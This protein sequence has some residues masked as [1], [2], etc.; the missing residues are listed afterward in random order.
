MRRSTIILTALLVVFIEQVMV[1]QDISVTAKVDTNEVT[2]GDWINLSL[3]VER[4]EAVRV[5]WPAILDT[6]AHLEVLRRGEIQTNKV[7]DK[8]VETSRCV[9]STIDSGYHQIP[10]IQFAY[11]VGNDTAKRLAMTYPIDLFV[12]TVPVDTTQDIK[13]VKPPLGIPIALWEIL[14]YVGI[15]LFIAGGGF[16]IYY[17]FRRRKDRWLLS[18]LPQR[19]PQDLA[20][21]ELRKLEDEKLWQRGLVKPYYTRVTEIVR[22]YIEGRFEVMALE[23]TTVEVM[24]NVREIAMSSEVRETLSVFLNEADFVKFAKYQPTPQENEAE[25]KMA[26]DI[27]QGTNPVVEPSITEEQTKVTVEDV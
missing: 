13:D 4:T 20:L 3:Q 21:I 24:H 22:R 15:V 6:I 7:G 11:T 17:Y 18:A 23:M 26:F 5:Y 2:I 14:L 19:P 12:H 8:I 27:V 1:G 25:L 10:P 9:L 16:G